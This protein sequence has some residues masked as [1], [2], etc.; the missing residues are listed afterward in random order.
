MSLTCA[1]ALVR[2]GFGSSEIT[3]S[4]ITGVR[5]NLI[6]VFLLSGLLLLLMLTM[7]IEPQPGIEPD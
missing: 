2:V 5:N 7:S 1:P 4:L 3:V 6:I